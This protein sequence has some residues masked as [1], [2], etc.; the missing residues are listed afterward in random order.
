VRIQVAEPS[1]KRWPDSYLIQQINDIRK[2]ISLRTDFMKGTFVYATVN[3]QRSYQ[4]TEM[5]KL[6]A[7]YIQSSDG[8][9]QELYGTDRMTVQGD[10]LRSYD[11]SS[12]QIVG[13]PTQTP[14]W[15]TQPPTAYP[16]QSSQIGGVVPTKLPW[17]ENAAQRPAY[18]MDGGYINILPPPVGNTST[19]VVFGVP[20][21]QELQKLSDVDV[22]PSNY[23]NAIKW[24]TVSLCLASDNNSQYTLAVGE[25]EKSLM[26]LQSW[27]DR[28]A[29]TNQ[30]IFVPQTIRR[31][32]GNGGDYWG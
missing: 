26:M 18:F 11:N 24:G 32:F 14:Q 13:Q 16:V 1:Q 5:V 9:Q 10:N 8:S 19:I 4:I 2:E 25:Y 28:L 3:G 20:A 6:F 7:V 30:K 15:L 17:G 23:I 29:A 31:S 21:P 12:G 27:E 22:Y